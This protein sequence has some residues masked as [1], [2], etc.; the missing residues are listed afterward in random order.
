[1]RPRR[2]GLAW[3]M[4][5]DVA[6]DYFMRNRRAFT[7]VELLVVIGIIALLVSILLPALNRAREQAKA[8][9]CRSNI[10]QILTAVVG[11]TNDNK[12]YLP[13]PSNIGEDYADFPTH[14]CGFF[15]MLTPPVTMDFDNGVLWPYLTLQNSQTRQ[16]VVN[17][18]SESSDLRPTGATGAGP[19]NFSYSF[20]DQLRGN[21]VAG[22]TE[23]YYG[24]KITQIIDPANK[25]IVVEE[26]WPNDT[27]ADIY[28]GGDPVG[29]RHFNGS[30]QGFADGHVEMVMPQ[31]IGLITNATGVSNATLNTTYCDLFLH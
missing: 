13:Q 10:R 26:A 9:V 18:P 19:R 30:N 15:M 25:I 6:E 28:G 17:C 2:A 1:M 24:I 22:A 3:A 5:L 23:T 12:F 29:N 27:N 16:T 21:S 8:V 31:D 4:T 11:Y 20:N 7:L 14:P